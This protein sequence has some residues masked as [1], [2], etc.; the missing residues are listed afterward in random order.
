MDTLS[1]VLLVYFIWTELHI[2]YSIPTGGSI[3]SADIEQNVTADGT[4]QFKM[5]CQASGFCH[6]TGM[7]FKGNNTNTFIGK[8]DRIHSIADIITEKN[9][10]T[11][12]LVRIGFYYTKLYKSRLLYSYI[13]FLIL[14]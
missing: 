1:V 5:E 4:A 2:I 8:F 7:E 12:V 14:F 11:L 3:K 9:E 10:H 6:R 13:L